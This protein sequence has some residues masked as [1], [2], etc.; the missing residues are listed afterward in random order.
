MNLPFLFFLLF[1]GSVAG[2]AGGFLLIYNERFAKTSSIHLISFAAGVMLAVTFLDILPEALARGGEGV[3][4]L[5]LIGLVIFFLL[6]DFILH[7]HH[8]EAHEH[9]LSSVVPLLITSDSI[10]N[11]IDGIVIT[12]SFLADP[13]LGAIVALAT[14]CHEIPQEIG[15]FA[16]LLSAGVAKGKVILY[17]FASAL[18]TFAGACLT[19]FLAE[20]SQSLIGPLLGLAAGMFLYISSADILPEIVK[21]TKSTIKWHTAGFF[22]AGVLAIFLLTKFIPD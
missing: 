10:H 12:A 20:K 2:L 15:D 5:A 19:L 1:L 4:L 6:E 13:R 17:N 9:A 7:F 11:A 18:A 21:G 22:L 16:V 3:F 14:F 8:H